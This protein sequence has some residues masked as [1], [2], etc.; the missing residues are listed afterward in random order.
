MPELQGFLATVLNMGIIRLPELE[1]YWKTSWVA[2]IPFFSRVMARD[3]FELIFWTLHVSHSTG[4]VKKV[5]KVRL[6]LDKILSN[7]QRMY[8]PSRELSVDET[9]LLFR[10]R[11]VG[12][13]YMPKK[14]IK[15]G[16]KC[17][18]L[19]DSSNGYILNV[20]PYTGRETLDEASTQYHSLPQ[21]AQVVMHLVDAYLDEGRHLFTD[22]YY[23]SI[24]LAQALVAR[25][26]DFTGTVVKNRVDLP[27]EI[28]GSLRLGADEVLAFRDGSLL[29]LAW[30]AAKKKQPVIMLS[31][32]YSAGMVDVPTRQPGSNTQRKPS[33][34]HMYNQHM[35]G[36]DMAD[37]H[38]VYYSFLRKTVKWWRKLFFWL[39][40]T[41]VVNR[42][43]LHNQVLTPSRPNHLT[44][45]RAIVE[46]LASRYL[47]SAPPR[48]RLG[49]PR[50]RQHPEQSDPERLNRQL[51]LLDKRP[52]HHD[53]VVCSHRPGERRRTPYVCKTCSDSPSLCPHPCFE[54]YHTLRNYRL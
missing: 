21:P 27:D 50:K 6:F 40:E 34:V 36:V 42:Y 49:R 1:H 19:A 53:C 5:D 35:N 46:S 52:Q 25:N 28:R 2:E 4:T 44:Y 43:I 13:Q 3:R 33:V 10:G 23:T 14:P 45:R 18:N 48:R 39:V 9:M 8:T 11:F 37:Q 54:R 20:L 47:A 32:K 7:S 26:T 38:A 12:K 51:H 17:F 30:R 16:I 41:A 15:W 29:A 22:R 24:P 31:T